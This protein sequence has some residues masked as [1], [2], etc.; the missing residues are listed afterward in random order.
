M[1]DIHVSTSVLEKGEAK[2]NQGTNR[3]N[4]SYFDIEVQHFDIVVQHFD[5]EAACFDIE[6]YSILKLHASIS[7][8]K[9]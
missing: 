2:R 8:V 1:F 9:I 6:V 4:R 5:I 3:S 7:G